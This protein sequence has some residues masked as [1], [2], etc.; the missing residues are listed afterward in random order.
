MDNFK[1]VEKVL[2]DTDSKEMFF[3]TFSM[4]QMSLRAKEVVLGAA[5]ED[6]ETEA[7]DQEKE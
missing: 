6:T 7:E 5:K 2:R 4:G 3:A 1:V